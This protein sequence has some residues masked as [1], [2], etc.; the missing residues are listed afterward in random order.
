MT[1]TQWQ[2]NKIAEGGPCKAGDN[3]SCKPLRD[4]PICR[5]CYK[6]EEDA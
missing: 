2:A 4:D 5:Q 3:E 6:E 1:F